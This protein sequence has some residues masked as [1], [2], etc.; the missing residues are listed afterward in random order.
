VRREGG[1]DLRRAFKFVILSGAR[2]E[3][4]EGS[5]VP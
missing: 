3:R 5:L 2:N 1:R 4:S